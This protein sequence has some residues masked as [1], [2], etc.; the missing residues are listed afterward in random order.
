MNQI[1]KASISLLI[2]VLLIA[3]TTSTVA[4]RPLKVVA[5]NSTFSKNVTTNQIGNN[6]STK[7]TSSSKNTIP[8]ISVVA[9][10]FPIYEFVKAVGGDRID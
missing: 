4:M 3:M 5:A 8:N 1:L 7:P 2:G 9:S 10:F 6:T